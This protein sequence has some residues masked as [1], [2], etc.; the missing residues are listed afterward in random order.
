[1]NTHHGARNNPTPLKG[2][3][4]S[5]G[6]QV[7]HADDRRVRDFKDAQIDESLSTHAR[8]L[9]VAEIFCEGEGHE[10][11]HR[12]Y[13]HSGGDPME[14]DPARWEL[15]RAGFPANRGW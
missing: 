8:T 15:L 4:G 2:I 5:I 9:A 11:I 3:L 6:G 10:S 12:F 1:M 14:Y 13:L 7:P